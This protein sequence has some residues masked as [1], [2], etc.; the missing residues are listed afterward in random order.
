MDAKCVDVGIRFHRTVDLRQTIE[1][2]VSLADEEYGTV[3]AAD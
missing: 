3:N 2:K 1:I